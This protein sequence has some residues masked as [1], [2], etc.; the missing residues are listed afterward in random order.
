MIQ[1]I[2][3]EDID[4]ARFNLRSDL[5]QGAIEDYART[6]TAS[7]QK[8]PP[9]T[10]C[11]IDDKFF[12]LDGFHRLQA[13]K[14]VNLEVLPA[15][16]HEDMAQDDALCLAAQ[17]NQTN[18]VRRSN[19]Y[20]RRQAEEILR[21]YPQWSDRKIAKHVNIDHK[22]V[23]EV[24]KAVTGDIPSEQREYVTKH[25]TAAVMKTGNIGK[26]QSTADPSITPDWEGKLQ[27]I[28]A[29]NEQSEPHRAE[30]ANEPS[31]PHWLKPATDW[32]REIHTAERRREVASRFNLDRGKGLPLAQDQ[33]SRLA[34]LEAGMA[35]VAHMDRDVAFLHEAH[36]REYRLVEVMGASIWNNP[37]ENQVDGTAAEVRDL[38]KSK[39]LPYKKGLQSRMSELRGAVLVCKCYPEPCHAEV[40]AKA[41]NSLK[42]AKNCPGCGVE[43]WEGVTAFVCRGCGAEVPK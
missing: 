43:C 6:Y 11:V 41:V 5:D 33:E 22:F 38:F 25:G 23:G 42:T 31:K 1:E 20:K 30:P 10:V 16:V 18:G 29:V 35:V 17:Q 14:Q 9:L 7:P 8:M 15:T 12:L 32:A 28:A 39:Y 24:R 3:I 27:R 34:Q 21:L 2:R 19:A 26:S 36:S 4:D 37:F 13:A 40:L